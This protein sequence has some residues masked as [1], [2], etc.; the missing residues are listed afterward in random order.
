MENIQVVEEYD[1][2]SNSLVTELISMAESQTQF[3]YNTT[4]QKLVEAI[5]TAD[6]R[7]DNYRQE[8]DRIAAAYNLFLDKHEHVLKEIDQD[9]SLEKKPLFQMLAEE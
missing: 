2:A 1:F 9:I 4:L 6:Q 5:R 3:R 7:V 8:Y